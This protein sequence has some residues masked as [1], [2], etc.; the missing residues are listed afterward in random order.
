MLL[1]V[2]QLTVQLGGRRVVDSLSFELDQGERLALIGESGSGKSLT[3]AAI[4]GLTPPGALVTGS[5]RLAGQE[6]LGLPERQLATLRGKTVGAVFQDPLTALD[7]I[8][9]VGR[10][11]TDSLRNHYRLNKTE[12]KRRALEM[13]RQVQL[14][15]PETFLRR[16]PHQLSGG[17][18]QRVALAQALISSPRLILADEPTTS[19]DVSVQAGVLDLLARLVQNLGSAQLFVTHDISLLPLVADRAIVMSQGQAV[20]KANLETLLQQPSHAVTQDLIK[21]ARATAWT[22]PDPSAPTVETG[23]AV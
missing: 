14:L 6:I 11:L 20:E 10:Q 3:L 1:E 8:R 19:L 7:P 16:Y 2:N 12:L 5:V 4:L 21:A 18:R 9:T 22:Q 13:L 23:A 17:Q 15:E